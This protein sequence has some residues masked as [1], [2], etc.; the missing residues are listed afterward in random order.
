MEADADRVI[1]RQYVLGKCERTRVTCIAF[2]FDV[3]LYSNPVLTFIPTFI[4][5][6]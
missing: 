6:F 2:K 5:L 1:C 3:L 4:P